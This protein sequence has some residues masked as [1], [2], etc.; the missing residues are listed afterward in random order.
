[1]FEIVDALKDRN[2]GVLKAVSRFRFRFQVADGDRHD[3]R[4]VATDK[5]FVREVFT[6][7]QT[8]HELVF[9]VPRRQAL[10]GIGVLCI[11]VPSRK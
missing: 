6:Q 5:R 2:E 8:F 3:Q 7:P 11:P 1:M 10:V 9:N 4:P